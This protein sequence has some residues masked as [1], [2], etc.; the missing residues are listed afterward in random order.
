VKRPIADRLELASPALTRTMTRGILGLP[1]PLRRSAL[2]SAF[3]RAQDAFNRGDLEAVFAAFSAEIEY[4]PPPP[5][6]GAGPIVG[7]DHVLRYWLGIFER[8]DENRIENLGVVETGRGTVRRTA[9]LRHA[10][11]G[12]R[13]D[14]E[15]LQTTEFSG[16]EVVRQVNE[17]R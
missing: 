3:E 4:L 5:L 2:A 15:I 8:F 13:L 11:A 7:R 14:Y 16:G 1:G 10:R 6:P 9:R 17:L 12:E